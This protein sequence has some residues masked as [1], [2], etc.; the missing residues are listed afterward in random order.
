MKT[1]SKSLNALK[2]LLA[3][4]WWGT[5]ATTVLIVV[6]APLAVSSPGDYVNYLKGYGQIVDSNL[7]AMTREGLPVA[8]EF[9]DNLLVK[10][11]LPAEHWEANRG[12]VALA[13][14]VFLAMMGAVLWFMHQLRQIVRSV[15]VGDPFISENAN[16]LRVMGLL[17]IFGSLAK[18]VSDFALSGYA[19]VVVKPVGFSLNG[20]LHGDFFS[21]VIGLSVLV[22]SEVLR[23]GA[24]MRQEQDLTI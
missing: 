16:R 12:L 24:A 15:E 18:S 1:K 23:V 6:L 17:I 22:L 10:L 5:I 4:S 19:D 9:E 3:I 21:L 7:T 2:V 14:G 8:V 13:F 20:H 11:V